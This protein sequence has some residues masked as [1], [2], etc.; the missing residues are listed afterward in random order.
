MCQT[1][2]HHVLHVYATSTALHN[3]ENT[4]RNDHSTQTTNSQ[5]D[6]IAG[7]EK[8]RQNQTK[9]GKVGKATRIENNMADIRD[10]WASQ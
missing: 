2:C 6:L 4:S 5:F 10:T 7:R 8:Y 3:T 9:D 1:L